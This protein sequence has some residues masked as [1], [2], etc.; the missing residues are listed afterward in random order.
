MLLSR[1]TQL[2]QQVPQRTALQDA[3][4]TLSYA[5]LCAAVETT[6]AALRTSG[7]R[8]LGLLM[9]N[10]PAWVVMDLAAIAAGI[11]VVPLPTFFSHQQIEHVIQDA[12]IDALC[13]DKCTGSDTPATWHGFEAVDSPVPMTQLCIAKQAPESR[14][15]PDG[16]ARITF[17]SGTTG[18]PKGVCLDGAAI[19]S[20]AESIVAATAECHIERHLCLLPLSL[21][22][23]NITGVYA[24]LLAGA[25]ILL[26]DS[27]E[28]GLSGSQQ[29]DIKQLFACLHHYRPD[30]LVLVP[31]MLKALT[32]ASASGL[33]VPDSLAFVAVGGAR[34]STALIT[35]ARNA[36]LPVYEGYGLS[37]CASVVSLNTPGAECEGSVGRPLPH[38]QV[39]VATDGEVLVSGSTLL[40]YTGQA[41]SEQSWFATGDLGFVDN[42]GFLHLT[43]RK[44]N[45]FVTAYGRNVNPEWPESELLRFPEIAQAVVYGEARSHNIAVIEPAARLPDA[46]ITD[47]VANANKQLPDYARVHGWIRAETFTP[48]S[49]LLTASGKPRRNAVW[50]RY[51]AM[52]ATHDSTTAMRTQGTG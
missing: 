41:A 35:A 31:Q 51:Q 28:R 46:A 24:P 14:V 37:E 5:E 40:G 22:L 21:L 6:A 19:F 47:C 45:V 15:L 43:G 7:I 4:S 48:E 8:T 34:V 11:T 52:I 1:L 9:D 50:D 10:S 38:V 44:K 23:E 13:T 2:A 49:G 30:S 39:K 26:P 29:L 18:N 16:T 25:T 3:R 20:V 27:A 12:G 33:P 32:A 42:N 17:T 36:G